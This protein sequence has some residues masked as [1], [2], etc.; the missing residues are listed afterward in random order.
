M[1]KRLD[2]NGVAGVGVRAPTWRPVRADAAQHPLVAGVI[3]RR[4]VS[5]LDPLVLADGL[6]QAGAR[7]ATPA[8]ARAGPPDQIA[9]RVEP[10]IVSLRAGQCTATSRRLPSVAC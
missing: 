7:Y 6:D 8:T 3:E 10:V 5:G 4:P 2:R 1:R 9:V